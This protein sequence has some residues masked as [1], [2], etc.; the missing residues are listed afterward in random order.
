MR[1]CVEKQS[2]E[3][4]NFHSSFMF[5]F[6]L[7]SLALKTRLLIHSLECKSK[8]V[9]IPTQQPA[10]AARTIRRRI[11]PMIKFI[12]E[13]F[14]YQMQHDPAAG[15]TFSRSLSFDTFLRARAPSDQFR[16]CENKSYATSRGWLACLCLC[17]CLHRT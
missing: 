5:Y 6:E 17:L 9:L 15:E 12:R 13:A 4:Q 11:S 2:A 1:R 3:F 16:S 8:F 7:S 10:A 14:Q